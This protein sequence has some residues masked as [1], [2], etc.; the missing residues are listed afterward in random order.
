MESTGEALK[1]HVSS[2]THDIL[3]KDPDFHLELR[4]TVQVKGKGIILTHFI[5]LFLR[6]ANNLLAQRLQIHVYSRFWRCS[7]DHPTQGVFFLGF[8]AICA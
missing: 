8:V 2:E 7:L 6:P 4:G 5:N 3:T 1:I